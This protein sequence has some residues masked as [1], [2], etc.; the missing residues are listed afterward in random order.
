[1]PSLFARRIASFVLFRVI[2]R[3]QQFADIVQQPANECVIHSRGRE[4][5]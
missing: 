1:M 2:A 5:Q 4:F 3:Q